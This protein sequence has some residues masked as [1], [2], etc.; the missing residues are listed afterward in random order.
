MA[1]VIAVW[2]RYE[3]FLLSCLVHGV[4]EGYQVDQK[5]VTNC[6]EYQL[7]DLVDVELCYIIFNPFLLIFQI[8][9]K[10]IL[11]CDILLIFFGNYSGCRCG[12]LLLTSCA[13]HSYMMLLLIRQIRAIKC[14]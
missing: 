12:H 14:I 13:Q 9:V 7:P 1:M 2:F 10:I 5:A 3:K 8:Y 6:D 11:P 4:E